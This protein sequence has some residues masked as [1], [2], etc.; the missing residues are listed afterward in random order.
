MPTKK[1]TLL[2]FFSS[3]AIATFDDIMNHLFRA[4]FAD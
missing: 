4:A 2:D 1:K 3:K